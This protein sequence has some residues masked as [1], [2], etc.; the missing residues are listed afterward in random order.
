[1]TIYLIRHA[2]SAF[3]AVY[4]PNMPDPMIFDAPITALGVAQAQQVRNKVKHLEINNVIVSPFIR[5]L[6]TAQLIFGKRLPYQINSEVREQLC[7]SC[8]VGSPPYKLARKYPH[9][10][11]SHL[12]DCWWHDGEKDHR[13]ISV[14]SE[15]ILQNRANMFTNFLKRE[16]VH[17]TAIVSHGN[18][19]RALTGIQPKNCEL[20]EFDPFN[21]IV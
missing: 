7:N 10:D 11:F 8:D 5:T 16:S 2:E 19:I 1:M 17:S 12:E 21:G 18:F 6:Q 9:L 4:D 13:G 14:E 15:E 3:N 20:I